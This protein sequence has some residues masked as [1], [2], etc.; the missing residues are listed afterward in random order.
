MNARQAKREAHRIAA[1]MIHQYLDRPGDDDPD[2]WPRIEA[3]LRDLAES[4]ERRS[5]PSGDAR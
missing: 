2:D 3:A 4:H 5:Y 1:L